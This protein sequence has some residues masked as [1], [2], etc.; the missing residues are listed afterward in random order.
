M[1]KRPNRNITPEELINADDVTRVREQA[2]RER[3]RNERIDQRQTKHKCIWCNVRG[4]FN[5]RCEIPIS[6]ESAEQIQAEK[7]L[8][9]F[10]C[11]KKTNSFNNY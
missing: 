8:C 5:N 7:K 9:R 1:S 10:C 11:S 4:H 6:R 3:M 2:R